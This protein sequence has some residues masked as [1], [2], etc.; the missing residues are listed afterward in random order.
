MN[1]IILEPIVLLPTFKVMLQPILIVLVLNIKT[2]YGIKILLQLFTENIYT[3][4]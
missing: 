1:M 2:S 4:Q 3:I